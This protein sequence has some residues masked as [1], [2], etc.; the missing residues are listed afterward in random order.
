M[1]NSSR[2][3]C[4]IL[5]YQIIFL[6][7]F[8]QTQPNNEWNNKPNVF[9]VNRL[10]VHATLIPY[11]DLN[12]ALQGEL[13]LSENYFSLNGKW[14][15]NL[16]TKPASR[17]LDFFNVNFNDLAWDSI[18][19]PGNWQT[20]GFDHPIYTNV[21]YP[22]SGYENISPPFAP[23]VYNPVGS[24][25]RTFTLPSRWDNNKCIL[26]FDGVES[27][28][29]V[30]I[31]GKYVGY[32]ENSYSPG[33]YDITNY[34]TVGS[35][36][37]AVQVFRWSDGSWL[38][39]QDFIR[40]SGIFRDVYI[41]KTPDVHVNDFFCTTD[42]DVN[43]QNAQFNFSAKLIADAAA[44]QAGYKVQVQLYDSTNV[45]VL[46]TPMEIPVTFSNDSAQISA[47]VVVTN[48]LKWSAEYPNL[49]KMVLSLIDNTGTTT[50][51]ESCNIGFRKF[52]LKNGQMLI[53]GKHILLKGVNRHETDP[54]K[55][56]AVDK[57]SMIRDV[58]IMKKFNINAVRTSH[59]PNNPIWYDLC[60]K[61]GL[62]LIDETNLESHGVR[63]TVPASLSA[64]T[65]NCVDRAISL[66][67]RDK[68]HPS[69]LIWSLGN[70]AGT[71]SN[72]QAMYNWIK[73]KD[74]T[75]L[76][77][78]EGDNKY[79]DMSS[80]MYSS[81]GT[82]DNYGKSANSKPLLLCEYAHSMGNSTGN[83]YQYWDVFEKYTDL[84]GGFIWD[85]VDQSI[86]D[87]VGYKY[88]GDWGDNPNDGNFCAN[89]IVNADRTLK[90]AIYEVKKVYQNLKMTPVDLLTGKFNIKNWFLFTNMNEYAGS[91]QLLADT[92]VLQQG[93]FQAA[94]MT[95]A[96]LG[97]KAIVVPFTKPQLQAGVKYWLN[98]SF[99]TKKDCNWSVAGHEI[100]KEQFNIPFVT[101]AV[102]KTD[103]FGSED[104][105]MSTTDNLITIQNSKVKVEFSRKTG[106]M[107]TYSYDAVLLIN[108][109]PVPNFWRAPTDNDRGNNEPSRCKTWEDASKERTLDTLFVNDGNK[110]KIRVFA[111]LTVPTQQKSGIIMTYDVMANG[112]VLV[113]EDFSPGS[114][115]L[116][117]IPLIGN[118]INMPAQFDRF[119]WYGKGPY[120]NYVDRK[121]ASDVGVYSKT[122]EENFFPYIQP[123]ETGNHIQT[124]WVKVVNQDNTG[125]LIAGNK[126]EFSALRYS[127]F[128]MENKLHPFELVKSA[129]TLLNINYKQMGV[130]GDDS[131]GAKPHDEFLIHPNSGYSYSYRIIPVKNG[132]NEMQV[133]Q[134]EYVP[135]ATVK[136][137]EIKGLS[138]E[139]A[140]QVLIQNGFVPGKYTYG[141]GSAYDKGQVMYQFPASD[142]EVSPGSTVSYTVSVGTNIALNKT[143][144]SSTQETANKAI[145]GNDGD[146]ATRWC[147]SNSSAGNWWSVDLGEQYDLSNYNILW[148]MADVYQ[149]KIEVSND[150]INWTMAVDK[151][152]N[153]STDQTQSG[154]INSKS[155]RYVRISITKNPSWYWSS[156]YEF[157]L[158]GEKSAAN[159][160]TDVKRNDEFNIK[161]F[162][163]PAGNYATIKYILAGPSKINLELFNSA[164]MKMKE[165]YS[166]F[167]NS[168]TY[169]L[170]IE[171]KFAPGVYYVRLSYGTY[172]RL[173]KFVMK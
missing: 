90:S 3:I 143:A 151:R 47:S 169:Q 39:D 83:L 27:A 65:A 132:S 11:N 34:L 67:E 54:I 59:Y 104:F 125:I 114:N 152:N 44:S 81:V 72:F 109:G 20:Q 10:K 85:F 46:S 43:Y 131:W 24:Y 13:K 32:S 129:N 148:E 73:S 111:Y 40:L 53:N 170:P 117:D 113:K 79:S 166:G 102:T 17:P 96:P 133:S 16:V 105:Q 45:A 172:S 36:T 101:P 68:N 64:W 127:P 55:G 9:Q 110:K 8:S 150:N 84:N 92:T 98:I 122:V 63:N 26:H 137:P 134:K 71:G 121:M 6:H 19:V 158:Y 167:Q 66:V 112:E 144:T 89:G 58:L 22:W 52:E 139:Q 124:N 173:Q 5:L 136:V 106:Q 145:S 130:G 21:T 37:I 76:V 153:A 75:R 82:V 108:N 78:Y 15:F 165:L 168:G 56:R 162:P 60:D 140:K 7:A 49:Y 149:F 146:Y 141:F 161:V 154:T 42:L 48:P 87:N 171:C 57:E 31:N 69:V 116:P 80:Y 41:Y 118:I 100:A 91:W 115:A 126:F 51:M 62:Y 25:R 160:V 138:E 155:V 156:F 128:E 28:Y 135:D 2:Q 147:A 120:E 23:T 14:K 4:L 93:D 29:Y 1:K 99:K 159:G 74:K 70:E 38:E 12:K 30:W 119:S 142:M 50:E 18:T 94:D 157:Q 164:G 95:L 103:N 33:E 107:N 163:N 86:K 35:N 88:G 61:Y 123:Q 77:H 97:K